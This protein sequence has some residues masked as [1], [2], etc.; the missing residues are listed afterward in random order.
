MGASDFCVLAEIFELVEGFE[1]DAAFELTASF[2]LTGIF[3]LVADSEE[4][5][6]S[7]LTVVFKAAAAFELAAFFELVVI[8]LAF[9]PLM[10][11]RQPMLSR[12]VSENR[13]TNKK[14][15]LF[16]MPPYQALKN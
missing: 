7:E 14:L 15:F 9:A 1:E 8:V 6:A 11:D 12:M 5:A 4:D 10:I 2:E 16:I 3:E 13:N